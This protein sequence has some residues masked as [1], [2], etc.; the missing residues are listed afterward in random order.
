[1]AFSKVVDHA[2]ALLNGFR[3]GFS[4]VLT[5]QE[6]ENKLGIKAD[7]HEHWGKGRLRL[8]PTYQITNVWKLLAEGQ[9][10]VDDQIEALIK[11]ML[12]VEQPLIKL[13]D[14][15][16]VEITLQVVRYFNDA[17]D[18]EQEIIE[19]D[20]DFVKLSGQHQLLGWYVSSKDLAFLARVNA[21]LDVDEYN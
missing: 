5:S 11:R 12:R 16:N 17:D 10:R 9:T 21:D 13:I 14:S 3:A 8:D 20:G 18:G 7:K 6:I 4:K 15:D 2:G 19:A 1:L